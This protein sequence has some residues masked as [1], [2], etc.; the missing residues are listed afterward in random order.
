MAV[1]PTSIREACVLLEDEIQK[2]LNLE[3]NGN[4]LAETFIIQLL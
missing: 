3:L 1:A 4:K 2:Y